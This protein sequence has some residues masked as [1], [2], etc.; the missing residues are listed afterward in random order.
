[1]PVRR[2]LAMSLTLAILVLAT[3]SV[4][5]AEDA[6]ADK[7]AEIFT[8]EKNAA[9]LPYADGGNRGN[10]KR[11]TAFLEELPDG[12]KMRVR[13]IT[14]APGGEPITYVET[15][16]SLN[17]KGKPDGTEL[18]FCDW[19]TAPVRKVP[20]KDG[21]K[22]GTE[23]IY[24]TKAVWNVDQERMDHVRYVYLG[25]PWD[26]GVLHGVKKSYHPSGKTASE[27]TYVRGVICGEARS[28]TD[29]GKLLRVA[30]YD[31]GVRHGKLVDYWPRTGKEKRV[32]PYEKGQVNGMARAC[33]MTG[34]PKWER[35]FKNNLQH[36]VEKHYS[37]DGT[38]EKVRY[39][40]AGEE[41]A[42][43]EFKQKFKP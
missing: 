32:V 16:T 41:V 34:K 37:E 31:K 24:E 39:W 19:Y 13:F 8:V 29:E 11:M 26:K 6:A 15:M 43:Q 1:M 35:P 18:H 9:A 40:I 27:T 5:A 17:A 2:R 3:A 14:R 23:L 33:Y 25:I 42:E 20:Y 7:E 36:G 10:G 38:V 4:R 28:Y 12:Y 22:H 30:R 21:V